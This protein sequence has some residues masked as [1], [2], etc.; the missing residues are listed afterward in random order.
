MG[1]N[2]KGVKA[3]DLFLEDLAGISEP[4]KKKSHHMAIIKKHFP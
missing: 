1:L 3:G 4:E 2:V